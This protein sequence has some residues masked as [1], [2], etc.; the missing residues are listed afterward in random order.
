VS[1][2]FFGVQIA[3]KRVA[4]DPLRGQ[5]HELLA[6]DAGARHS[7]TAKQ[8]FWKR[9]SDLLAGATLEYGDWDL[10]RGGDAQDQF[11]EWTREIEASASTDPE[12]TGAPLSSSY[13]LATAMV[14]VDR[15]SNADQTLGNEC[16][17]PESAWLT[18]P[19]FAQLVSIFPR[20]NFANVQADAFY[21]VPGAD[22]TGPSARDLVS[23]D[24]GL[25]PLA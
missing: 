13:V 4:G 6:R 5:L 19:T 21:V 24:Y 8:R 7:L 12:D 15:G 1:Y 3:F 17:I 16:D 20:L 25:Q 22:R 14:L 9:V 2:S 18:R 10:V 23:T 11:N